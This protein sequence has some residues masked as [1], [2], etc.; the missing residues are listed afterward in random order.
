MSF[1]HYLAHYKAYLQSLSKSAYTVKQYTLDNQ[2]FI[3]FLN[4]HHMEAITP[5][6]IVKYKQILTENYSTQSVNRKLASLK[7]FLYFLQDRDVID[8]VD[9]SILQPYTIEKK[10]LAILSEH[11]VRQVLHVWLQ[12]YETAKKEEIR[13]M[14][15]RNYTIM[16]VI[17]T[18]GL[19]SS[20][21][22]RMKWQH[23]ADE[24]IRILNRKTFRIVPLPE[25]LREI[26]SFYQE[27]T[28]RQFAIAHEVDFMWLGLGNKEGEPITVK[29]IE[30]LL[31]YAS[32]QV[33]FLVTTT[34]LRYTALQRDLATDNEP[35]EDLFEKYGYARKGVLQERTARIKRQQ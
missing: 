33:G 24:D 29:T 15:L 2:Q 3:Q 8:V 6:A 18:L 20:E 32:E 27:E 35:I 10:E 30:R 12:S 4:E 19:K 14:A 21:V 13:W 28:Q 34:N 17:A 25:R 22:V 26:L 1:S 9:V 31:A 5:E 23:I 11:E 16:R 7:S